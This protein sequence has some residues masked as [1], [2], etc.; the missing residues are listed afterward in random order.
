[1]NTTEIPEGT[2]HKMP[3]DLRKALVADQKVLALWEDI[4]PLARNEFI[5]WVE[6]AKQIETRARRVRRTCEELLDGQRRPCCWIGC[7]H[8]TDKAVSP[9]VQAMLDKKSRK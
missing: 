4:T 5:C 1:M 3:A 6:N 2:V 7:T 9:S 8:R